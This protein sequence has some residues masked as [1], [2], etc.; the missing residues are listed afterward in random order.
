VKMIGRTKLK[1]KA[2]INN[3][4]KKIRIVVT[5]LARLE[6]NATLDLIKSFSMALCGIYIKY[7]KRI[8]YSSGEII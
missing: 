5:P 2:T 4:T 7:E 1:I 3:N 6:M 8:P